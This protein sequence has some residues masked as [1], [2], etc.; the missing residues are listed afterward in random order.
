MKRT[1]L[2]IACLIA[3]NCFAQSKINLQLKAQLDTILQTDQGIREFMDT[4]TNEKRKDTLA[5]VLGY[6]K[7]TLKNQ[8]WNIMGKIDGANVAKVE[9]IIAQYGYPG[10][11]MVGEPENTTV[12]FVIQ[13]SNKIEKYY[14]LIAEA[15]KK[16]ELPFK[17][18]AMMLDRKLSNEN[19]EQIYGTQMYFQNVINPKTGKKDLQFGY[20]RPIKD[21][22]NV[23]KR[24][25]EAGFDTTVEEN[26]RR[27]D[28]VYKPYTF[29]QI[30]KIKKGE[31]AIGN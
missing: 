4:S 16:G 7:D 28:I 2:I 18:V 22:A 19:K 12:F 20:V 11:T 27:F 10:K 9:R 15:G 30:E 25:K 24:R 6:P 21:A 5:M 13:H 3:G 23:N 31:L 29:E 8:Q 14:S 26:A 17:Y 1:L